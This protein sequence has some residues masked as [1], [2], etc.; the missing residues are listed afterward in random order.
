M[1]RLAIYCFNR[2][3]NQK[4]LLETKLFYQCMK[5]MPLPHEHN[6]QFEKEME[7]SFLNLKLYNFDEY[8][9]THSECSVSIEYPTETYIIEF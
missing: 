1:G 5:S 3:T 8:T 9:S 7:N 4:W 2:P 6:S